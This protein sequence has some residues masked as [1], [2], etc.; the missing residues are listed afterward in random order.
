M[1]KYAR[2][3]ACAVG[4]SASKRVVEARARARVVGD[5]RRLLATG[6]SLH[7]DDKGEGGGAVDVAD[8]TDGR[9][10]RRTRHSPTTTRANYSTPR[11]RARARSV[12]SRKC[13]SEFKRHLFRPS[14]RSGSRTRR[15]TAK[16]ASTSV[17]E[18]N[19]EAQ[20]RALIGRRREARARGRLQ[21]AAATT[22]TIELRAATSCALEAGRHTRHS[23]HRTFD[24]PRRSSACARLQPYRC[25]RRCRRRLRSQRRRRV[26]TAATAAAAAAAARRVASADSRCQAAHARVLCV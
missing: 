15:P 4:D 25:R 1:T 14:T 6:L 17:C 20:E 21:T 7:G 26:A 10:R 2:A 12:C 3:R 23:T 19:F 13:K 18:R 8:A 22:L 9:R 24:K 16:M 5:S 11:A